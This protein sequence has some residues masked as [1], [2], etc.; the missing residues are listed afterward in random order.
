SAIKLEAQIKG[1]AGPVAKSG[2]SLRTDADAALRRN[3][4]RTR[5][6]ELG[7]IAAT[8]PEDAGNWRRLAKVIFQITPNR[9]SEQTFLLERA[10]R[11]R[12]RTSLPCRPRAS[13][14]AS[15]G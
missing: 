14:S 9:S 10:S 7:Q 1:E 5:L 2:A 13:S 8:T 11:G 3:D 6:S 15:T 4:Y 12:A